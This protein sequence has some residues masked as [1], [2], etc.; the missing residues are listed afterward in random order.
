MHRRTVSALASRGPSNLSIQTNSTLARIMHLCQTMTPW[1]ARVGRL[2]NGNTSSSTSPRGVQRIKDR[3]RVENR[4]RV[5]G[6]T[7]INAATDSMKKTMGGACL[8]QIQKAMRARH[9][10]RFAGLPECCSVAVIRA[11]EGAVRPVLTGVVCNNRIV[12]PV[13]TGVVCNNRMPQLARV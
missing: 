11:P 3:M 2:N 12:R 9:R 6:L 4:C 5:I 10:R 13:S 8:T 7:P 1:C